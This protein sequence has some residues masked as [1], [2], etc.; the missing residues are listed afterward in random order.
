MKTWPCVLAWLAAAGAT[1]AFGQTPS[2][3]S[4]GPQRQRSPEP[5]F[6]RNPIYPG[7]FSVYGRFDA[8][9]VKVN[10]EGPCDPCSTRLPRSYL[11]F[12][13]DETLSDGWIA[14]FRLEHSL[15]LHLGDTAPEQPFWTTASVGL[16]RRDLGRIDLGRRDQPAWLV[17]LQGDPWGGGTVASPND[18]LYHKPS[19]PDTRD[20]GSVTYTTP[21]Y[22]EAAWGAVLQWG[23]PQASLPQ[24]QWGASVRYDRGGLYVGLG[25]QRWNDG[26]WA[27]PLAGHYRFEKATVH[28][29]V[30]SGRADGVHYVS[31]FVGAAVPFMSKG[32]PNREE[33]RVGIGRRNADS[34]N[35][36]WKLGV[37]W[38][39]RFSRRTA[40][41][42]DAAV[43]HKV[44]GRTTALNVGL[45]H[46]FSRDL[47]LPQEPW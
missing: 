6:D 33:L 9:F 47:R 24:R 37:G 29:A 26:S 4:S 30:T 40:L 21:R 20:S 12:T 22:R 7:Q 45:M 1:A 32:D 39:Y 2:L 10:G 36:D 41:H 16:S 3:D 43:G 15:N 44:G 23:N 13:G 35:S 5:I 25:R 34:G 17:S 19:P 38:Q 11:G 28:A 8:G 18:S 42:V 27:M 46:T 14:H 31:T